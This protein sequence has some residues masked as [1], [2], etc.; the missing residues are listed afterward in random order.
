LTVSVARPRE[1]KGGFR[2]N[3]GGGSSNNRR[4]L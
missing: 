3:R 1:E 2:Q 4:Y